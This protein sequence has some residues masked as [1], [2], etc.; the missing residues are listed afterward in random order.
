[1]NDEKAL[2]EL[3]EEAVAKGA[4]TAEEIHR[5][6]ADLPLTVL[7]RLGLFEETTSEV[8][9]IQEASIGAVYDL[10]RDVN[11]KVGKLATELLEPR[12]GSRES[13]E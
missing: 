12:K 7:E 6:V 2:M 11:H 1:M 9:K 13:S 3:V 5:S 4:T 8:R 10:I